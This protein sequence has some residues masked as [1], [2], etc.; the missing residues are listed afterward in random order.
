MWS[1][2]QDSL[3]SDLKDSPA[4]RERLPELEAAVGE[5]RVPATTAAARLLEI[6]LDRRKRG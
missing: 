4:V 5:G 2:L 1:D 3:M 6:Y